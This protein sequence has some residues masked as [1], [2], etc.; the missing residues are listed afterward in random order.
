MVQTGKVDLT[1][2]DLK[3]GIREWRHFNKVAS[4]NY[5]MTKMKKLVKK[6]IMKYMIIWQE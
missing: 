2:I 5:I 3:G 4:D 1:I 6:N